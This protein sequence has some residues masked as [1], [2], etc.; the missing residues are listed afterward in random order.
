MRKP[1]KLSNGAYGMGLW[2]NNDSATKHHYFRGLYG[3]YIIIIPE[4]NMVIVRTGMN[5]NENLDA[6][7]RPKE[8]EKYVQEAA[9]IYS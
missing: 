9:R 8:V 5:K 3:Q 7:G 4:K 6:K 2:I 1:T